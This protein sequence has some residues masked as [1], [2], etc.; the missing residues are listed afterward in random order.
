MKKIYIF[1]VFLLFASGISSQIVIQSEDKPNPENNPGI[2]RFAVEPQNIPPIKAANNG[3]W[4]LSGSSYTDPLFEISPKRDSVVQIPEANLSINVDDE[5]GGVTLNGKVYFQHNSAGLAEVGTAFQRTGIRITQT[6]VPTDSL[7]IPNQINTYRETIY[8]TPMRHDDE[9][10]DN[11]IQ[12]TNFR[13]SV[14][15][16]GLNNAMGELRTRTTIE[17]DISGWGTVRL[18]DFKNGG[19]V[20]YPCL[21][22][23]IER[24]SVDSFFINN[25]PAPP[26]LMNLFGLTQGD[27]RQTKYVRFEVKGFPFY[28]AE[29]EFEDGD[30]ENIASVMINALSGFVGEVSSVEDLSAT[31]IKVYPNPGKNLFRFSMGNLSVSKVDVSIFDFGG[32]LVAKYP[33]IPVNGLEFDI[34]TDLPL[35]MYKYT[36]T[37]ADQPQMSLS[38][39]ISVFD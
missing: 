9:R 23:K 2:F 38:G 27:E 21:F 33:N 17:N 12:R 37:S 1:I 8:W 31:G 22:R 36:V 10:F 13:I 3:L 5:F 26:L 6:G 15:L 16:L 34:N 11:F 20:D 29:V 24:R 28:A 7:I 39:N 14:L 4:D 30:D 18:P 32:R 19:T 25:M 35:G